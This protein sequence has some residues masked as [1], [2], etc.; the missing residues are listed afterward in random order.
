MPQPQRPI[1]DVL[2]E[3]S[4][5]WMKLPGVTGTA[6]GACNGHPCLQ[7]Y[8]DKA[9]GQLRQHLPETVEGYDV[10]L[11]ETGTFEAR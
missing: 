11:I 10:R 9:T 3:Q 6:I 8:V 4:P 5:R 7:V 1:D 2:N